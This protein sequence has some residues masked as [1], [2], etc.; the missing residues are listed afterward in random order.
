MEKSKAEYSLRNSAV[1]IAAK[2]VAILGGYFTRI[3]L[4]MTVAPELVG[5]NGLFFTVLG[6]FMLPSMFLETALAYAMY[7]SVVHNDREKQCA[8]L[9]YYR[10]I[11]MVF[12]A[13]IL[14][15][16]IVLYFFL[17][18]LIRDT[19]DPVM[20]G[21]AYGLFLLN[22]FLSYQ[23]ASKGMMFLVTQNNYVN[24]LFYTGFWILQYTLQCIL[25]FTT[26]SFLI[27]LMAAVLCTAGRNIAVTIY[28]NKK[29]PYI[30][31]Q[32]VIAIS[33]KEKKT[34][35]RNI[36]AMLLHKSGNVII[37][38][39]DNLL[40]SSMFGVASVGSYSNYSLISGSV[41]QLFSKIISGI[42]ASVGHIGVTDDRKHLERVFSATLLAAA[43]IFGFGAICLFCLLDS[44]VILSFG[45]RYLLP[46]SFVLVLC[47]N[48]YIDGIRQA[49]LVFRD[50]MGLFWKDRYKTIVEGIV[51]LLV[52]ILLAHL[53]GITGILVGTTVSYLAVSVWV[54]PLVLYREGFQ[55]PV[56]QYF[57]KMLAMTLC[58]SA[59]AG[60]T[61]LL[62]RGITGAAWWTLFARGLVC[63][64]VPNILMLLL[65]WKSEEL[66]LLK[67]T[68]LPIVLK[69][70]RRQP[71]ER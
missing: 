39:T 60:I 13:V 59:A 48:V 37:T 70:F 38:N 50:A 27:Y 35:A 21:T 54:E 58:V 26:K 62:C 2:M 9:A 46:T 41:S 24:E 40:L 30:K 20:L 28:A 68:F 34:L 15:A 18:L 12:S 67:D 47:I 7:D 22:T 56:L 36:R 29:F 32:S 71:T 42:S 19:L 16:G 52:S 61:W 10:R 5:V 66:C 17:P 14:L 33:E 44:F 3:V 51:N 4:V 23:W 55:A 64:V 6:G 57:R 25:L 53:M 63:L 1:G 43:W 69:R 8:L 65:F 31:K 11:Y 45:E 49:T